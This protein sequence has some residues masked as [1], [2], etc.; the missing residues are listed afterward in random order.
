MHI[1]M[2]IDNTIEILILNSKTIGAHE[3]QKDKKLKKNSNIIV[4][5]NY[6][7]RKHT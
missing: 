4:I 1:K 2:F 6:S 7:K 3:V 5:V